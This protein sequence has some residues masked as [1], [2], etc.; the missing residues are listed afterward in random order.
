MTHFQFWLL[1]LFHNICWCQQ[2]IYL[3][4]VFGLENITLFLFSFYHYYSPFSN[5]FP[6]YTFSASTS[7]FLKCILF[8]FVDYIL[9]TGNCIHCH[10]FNS[11]VNFNRYVLLSNCSVVNNTG[12]KRT[13]QHQ[14]NYCGRLQY[15][16]T[17]NRQ[18][19]HI[20]KKKNI[21]GGSTFKQMDLIDM[22]RVFH[23]IIEYTFSSTAHGNFAKT[24]HI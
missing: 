10:R 14:Y 7:R 11:H 3:F 9:S 2:Q 24:D 17:T 15:P 19:K 8:S 6:G 5:S 21:S 22:Y 20:H 12:Q 4:I 13:D 16:T 18:V 23:T 1:Q